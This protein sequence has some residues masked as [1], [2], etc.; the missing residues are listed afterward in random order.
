[1]LTE[2]DLERRA[3]VATTLLWDRRTTSWLKTI[4]TGDEI[5]CIYNEIK[6]CTCI[7]ELDLHYSPKVASA[8]TR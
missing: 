3:D 8:K 1:M 4:I 7:K 5:W 2:Y 6:R